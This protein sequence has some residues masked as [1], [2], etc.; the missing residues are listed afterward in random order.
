MSTVS[1]TEWGRG[2]EKEGRRPPRRLI[3]HQ[4]DESHKLIG[5]KRGMEMVSHMVDTET[6]KAELKLIG[7]G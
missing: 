4:G 3:G 5:Y 2:D 6:G 1:E 7:R